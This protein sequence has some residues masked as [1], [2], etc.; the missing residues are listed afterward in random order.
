MPHFVGGWDGEE[1]GAE[2]GVEEICFGEAVA[3]VG[4]AGVDE[5]GEEGEAVG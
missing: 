4:D 2:D 3:V 1:V 5:G